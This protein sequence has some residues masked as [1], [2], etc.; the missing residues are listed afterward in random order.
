[1]LEKVSK[2]RKLLAHAASGDRDRLE[3]ALEEEEKRERENDR[4]YWRPLKQEL[5]R[6]RHG[7]R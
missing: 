5:E 4:K 7:K 3:A 1:M 6:I 2:G